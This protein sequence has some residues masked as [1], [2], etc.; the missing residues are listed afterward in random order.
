MEFI[1]VFFRDILDGPI[2][3][4]VCIFCLLMICS[5]IGYL[6]ERYLNKKKSNAPQTTSHVETQDAH[7]NLGGQQ[8]SLAQS[9]ASTLGDV[10]STT[11]TMGA[12]P[13]NMGSPGYPMSDVSQQNVSMGY[14]QPLG[15]GSMSSLNSA[16]MNPTVSS[17]ASNSNGSPNP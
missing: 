5:C 14:Q 7:L 1:I 17:G 2:Y 12:N 8:V 16:S 15:T 4:V 3:I 9:N 6:G 11:I 13:A 10:A